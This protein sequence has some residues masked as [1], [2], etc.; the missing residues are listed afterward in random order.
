MAR[1]NITAYKWVGHT[2][3]T[4]GQTATGADG[5]LIATGLV[6]SDV[7]MDT[8]RRCAEQCMD[9]VVAAVAEVE[10]QVGAALRLHELRAF[11]ASDGA[12]TDH[13]LVADAAS[14]RA[15]ETFGPDRGQHVRTTVGVTGL[16]GGSPVEV[17]ATFTVDPAQ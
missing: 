14:L 9:N 4:S 2:V 16:P 10:Q 1:P 15:L 8:A 3:T 11:V 12:F 13:H 17:Q 7:S 6:G 5:Q